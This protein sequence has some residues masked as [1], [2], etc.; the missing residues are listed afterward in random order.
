MG[1]LALHARDAVVA[2]T[3]FRTALRLEKSARVWSGL[4]LALCAQGRS[5]DALAPLQ[6]ALDLDPDGQA[7][8]YGLVQAALQIGALETAERRLRD[9]VERHPGNLGFS[10]SL[11][12]IA[13]Q[14]GKREQAQR[15]VEQIELFD[16]GYAGLAELRAKLLAA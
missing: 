13:L 7:A 8:L 15:L 5:R 3:H 16:P 2:E 12:A 4:G 10:F 1:S 11:A 6:A 9:Y 14:L